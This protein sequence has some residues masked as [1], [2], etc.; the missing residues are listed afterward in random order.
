MSRVKSHPARTCKY[1]ASRDLAVRVVMLLLPV[2]RL[3]PS[4][5]TLLSLMYTL[6]SSLS[7]YPFPSVD[8][9]VP[10]P[11]NLSLSC[12]FLTSIL[13]PLISTLIQSTMRSLRKRHSWP[14][15]RRPRVLYAKE[16]IDD[17]PFAY[18]IPPAEDRDI[19]TESYLAA[20][21]ASRQRSRSLSP[22]PVYRKS[23]AKI[24]TTKSPTLRLKKW[25]ERMERYYFHRSPP[26]PQPQVPIIE[27]REPKQWETVSPSIRGRRDFRS[28]SHNRISQTIRTPPRKPRVWREPSEGIWTVVEEGEDVGLGISV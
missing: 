18:F 25:I 28:S 3:L 7:T 13:F 4:L 5:R 1:G 6:R 20:G 2:Y 10:R 12:H 16:K 24:S 14:P 15:L 17:D 26:S 23:H 11:I 22:T 21:I 9:P 8:V 19:F 27:V